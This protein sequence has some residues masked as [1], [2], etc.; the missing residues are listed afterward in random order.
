MVPVEGTVGRM[1]CSAQSL[2]CH[3]E[4]SGTHLMDSQH[5]HGGPISLVNSSSSNVEQWIDQQIC[6][7]VL[8]NLNVAGRR[9]H[10]SSHRAVRL[11]VS[12]PHQLEENFVETTKILELKNNQQN[13]GGGPW[14]WWH[15]KQAQKMKK[16]FFNARGTS[17]DSFC[18]TEKKVYENDPTEART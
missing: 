2:M 4:H 17:K 13:G 16:I 9:L 6:W 15:N 12:S 8:H 14:T 11:G 3:Q 7:H 1:T 18:A 5:E 10:S